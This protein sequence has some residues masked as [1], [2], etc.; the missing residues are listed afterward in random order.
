MTRSC[1]VIAR[2]GP[3]ARCGS[4]SAQRCVLAATSGN[5]PSAKRPA[6]SATTDAAHCAG[7]SSAT[8]YSASD[9]AGQSCLPRSSAHRQRSRSS[10]RPS[11]SRWSQ[12]RSI[13]RTSSSRSPSSTSAL[14]HTIGH[15]YRRPEVST[16]KTGLA[17]TAF[18]RFFTASIS[19]ESRSARNPG[20]T[21]RRH[22]SD[23]LDE[24]V[25]DRLATELPDHRAQ[26]RVDREAQAVVDRVDATVEAEQAVPA[27][28]VG[29][30]HEEVEGRD[31]HELRGWVSLA[32]VEREVVLL[33]VGGDEQLQRSLTERRVVAEHRRRARCP[34]RAPRRARTRRPRACAG[35]SGSPTGDARPA[36]AC[37][38]PAPRSPS[39]HSST[40]YVAFEL[41]GMRPTSDTSPSV[42]SVRGSAGGQ[43]RPWRSVHSVTVHARA[44][45]PVGVQRAAAQRARRPA[46]F[47]QPL[48]AS[49]RTRAPGRV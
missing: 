32:V 7:A 42:R 5:G 9:A 25:R 28:A 3:G 24:L 41:H 22:A 6:P 34:S 16:G 45:V 38:P 13:S 8:R 29:V 4:S 47:D 48:R 40:R 27:L 10:I 11:Q 17:T 15:G 46:A 20:G 18:A 49:R 2:N 43:S 26:L 30:V 21:S 44:D 33:E 1:A 31:R 23:V 35:R 14:D 39:W 37:T 36:P 19:S 12:S